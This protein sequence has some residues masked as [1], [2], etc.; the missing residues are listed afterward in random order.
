MIRRKAFLQLLLLFLIFFAG[1]VASALALAAFGVDDIFQ[2]D[3]QNHMGPREIQLAIGVG[4]FLGMLLPGI[5]ALRMT[6]D[7]IQSYF[8]KH[9]RWVFASL[10]L[11][12]LI[13]LPTFQAAFA[14]NAQFHPPQGWPFEIEAI[15]PML[16]V[17][18]E[19]PSIEGLILNLIILAI[20]P[21]VGEEIIFRGLGLPITKN[22]VGNG[23]LAVIITSAIFS[24]IHL[25]FQGLMPRMVLGLVLG[26]AFYYSRNLLI[27]ILIHFLH[28]ASQVFLTFRQDPGVI[29]A[30][31]APEMPGI[32]WLVTSIAGLVAIYLAIEWKDYEKI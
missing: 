28:N 13:S 8:H 26:Y 29:R 25:D 11:S 9:Q 10:L 1:Q 18:I 32:F 21:A 19:D 4:Q 15:P 17:L 31:T 27:P 14:W 5:I 6:G 12:Y 22:L 16:Y 7:P 2:S 30:E 24:F 23:H 20:L 3:I